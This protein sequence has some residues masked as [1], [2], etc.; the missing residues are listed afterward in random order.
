MAQ[1][2]NLTCK[3]HDE[4]GNLFSV[5]FLINADNINIIELSERIG[6]WEQSIIKMDNGDCIDAIETKEEIQKLINSINS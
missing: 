1:M 3:K 6:S 2:I 4:Q 5:D